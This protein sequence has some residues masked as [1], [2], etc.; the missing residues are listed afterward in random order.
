MD[1]VEVV[2]AAYTQHKLVD[3]ITVSLPLSLSLTR[4]FS[5]FLWPAFGLW[6]LCDVTQLNLLPNLVPSA[7]VATFACAFSKKIYKKT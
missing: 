1:K 3:Y 2:N 7:I 4:S 5:L 6:S